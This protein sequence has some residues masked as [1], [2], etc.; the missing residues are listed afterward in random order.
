[1]ATTCRSQRVLLPL[2]DASRGAASVASNPHRSNEYLY[3]HKI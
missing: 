3:K 1:M 2:L